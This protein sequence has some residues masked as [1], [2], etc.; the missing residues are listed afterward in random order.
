MGVHITRILSCN[1]LFSLSWLTWDSAHVR[2]CRL[3]G[4]HHTSTIPDTVSFRLHF[5]SWFRREKTWMVLYWYRAHRMYWLSGD[6]SMCCEHKD[7]EWWYGTM[8]SSW[9]RP[10]MANSAIKIVM[11]NV[12]KGTTN[13]LRLLNHRPQCSESGP[14][15]T[16]L[17]NGS[18]ISVYCYILHPLVS[19]NSLILFC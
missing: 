12:Y 16:V 2:M 11:R 13:K 5:Q 1:P 19:C 3:S 9:H 14:R 17:G 10:Q 7:S 15:L 8:Q 6:H 18:I 4:L